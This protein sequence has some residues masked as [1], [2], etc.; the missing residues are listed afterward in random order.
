MILLVPRDPASHDLY[1]RF[2]SGSD[3]SFS[4]SRVVP[5]SYTLVAIQDG[6]TLEWARPE[7]IAP[8]LARGV[9]MQTTGQKTL[10][11]PTAVEVQPR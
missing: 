4:L 5:G 8:Y 6:W 7:V 11:L 3:G 2:Q 10:E 1:R 9:Q